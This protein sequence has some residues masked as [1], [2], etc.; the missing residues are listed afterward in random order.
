MPLRLLPSVDGMGN[1]CLDR[2]AHFT[3]SLQSIMGATETFRLRV[4]GMHSIMKVILGDCSDI[5]ENLAERT[6]T[7]TAR[8]VTL[9]F[10]H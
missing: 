8:D 4:N 9:S 6:L 10:D 5:R 3:Q 7:S 1:S 2:G